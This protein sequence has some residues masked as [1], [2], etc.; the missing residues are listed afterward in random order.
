MAAPTCTPDYT[1]T[2]GDTCNTISLAHNVS[3]FD[4]LYNNG[5]ESYCANF[6][7]AGHKLCL[8]HACEIYTVQS[9]DSCHRI[10]Q[11]HHN[12]FT[13]SQM[14]SWN[15][16]INRDCSN[17]DQLVGS[18]I[19]ISFPGDSAL[20]STTTNTTAKAPTPPNV[21]NGTNI[22]CARYYNISS[23][24]YCALVTVQQRISLQDFY[25]LNAGVNS[26]CGNLV[27]GE[28]YCV[29]AVG[30]IAIYPGYVYIFLPFSLFTQSNSQTE[31]ALPP[32]L[33]TP[34]KLFLPLIAASRPPT[35]RLT[36]GLG[37]PTPLRPRYPQ[38]LS[39]LHQQKSLS[40]PALQNPAPA[41]SLP[42]S[43]R[44]LGSPAGAKNG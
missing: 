25:F 1:I 5:L 12:A 2:A 31:A 18:Q 17:M 10:V 41:V 16:N 15:I 43:K 35:P 28:S 21:A 20:T 19:C 42:R 44:S 9:N 33:K 29:Q 24:D 39:F 3:T 40:P 38:S 32:A 30:D 37:R 22:N 23:G 36:T 7:S 11:A 4:L 27:L 13:I 26:T 14:V 34:A 8:P 6:P